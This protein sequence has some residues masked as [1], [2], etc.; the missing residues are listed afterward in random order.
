MNTFDW[1]EIRTSD[2]EATAKFYESLFGWKILERE[3]SDGFDYWIFD[4]NGEPRMENL[5]RGG[6]WA[7]PPG[8]LRGVFT[9]IHVEDIETKLKQVKMLGGR[10]IREKS[11]AGAGSMAVISD[12]CENFIGLYQDKQ[13]A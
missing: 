4:T 1:I 8:E 2:I 13:S 6:I 11:P 5:R 12:P 3:S 9:F 7:R 10:V